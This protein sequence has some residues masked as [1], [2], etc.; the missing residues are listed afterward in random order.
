M[1][2]VPQRPGVA[3][4]REGSVEKCYRHKMLRGLDEAAMT[5]YY[6]GLATKVVADG[7]L[8]VFFD[9]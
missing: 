3:K 6:W 4:V 1:L 7:I 8:H 2:A 9:K 5:R